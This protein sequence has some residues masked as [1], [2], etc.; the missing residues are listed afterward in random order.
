VEKAL[1]IFK[2]GGGYVFSTVHN[3]QADV[4]PDNIVCMYEAFMKN[5]AY[6]VVSSIILSTTIEYT[7][8]LLT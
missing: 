4:Y 3:L 2:P 1:K 8:F 6:L 5:S 7:I